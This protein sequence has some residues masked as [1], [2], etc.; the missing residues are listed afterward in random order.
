MSIAPLREPAEHP[1]QHLPGWPQS[2]FKIA[3]AYAVFGL[4]WIWITDTLLFWLR[5]QSVNDY[6]GSTAKGSLFVV[7]SAL[8][9]YLISDR[10]LRNLSRVSALLQ[11]VIDGTT[12]AIFVKDL[13]GRYLLCNDAVAQLAGKSVAEIL[14]KDD[15][16]LFDPESARALHQLDT[17][18]MSD[19][20][21]RTQEEVLTSDGVTRVYSATKAPY[22]DA[23]GKVI[24]LIG[25]S[26]DITEQ[27]SAEADLH[28]R[29]AQITALHRVGVIC[30]NAAA[31]DD[32]YAQ[33]TRLIANELF[34]DNCGFL[35]VDDARKEMVT[36]P[37]YV[38]SPRGEGPAERPLGAGITGQVAQTGIPY[39]TGNVQ[40]E[41]NYIADVPTMNS[42]LCVPIR[43]GAEVL[44]VLNVESR[45][46]DAFT[47]ADESALCAMAELV[48][49]A[50]GRLRNE[51]RLLR[52]KERFLAF[53]RN[54]PGLAWIKNE[55]GQYVFGNQTLFQAI[56]KTEDEI[57]GHTDVEVLPPETAF[58]VQAN[59]REV[60][61]TA[62]SIQKVE[63]LVTSNGQRH[64]YLVNKFP[65]AV[66]GEE[67]RL[68][69][70]IAT[71][72]T[73][74]LA[75]EEALKQSEARLR[76]ALSASELGVWEWNIEADQIYWSPECLKITGA[77]T[78]ASKLE[79][80]SKVIHPDDLAMV[81]QKITQAIDCKTPFVAEFRAIGADGKVRWLY[82]LGR[83]EY[84]E[85]GRP[86]RMI[87]A[88]QDITERKGSQ[89]KLLL[90]K[91]L[92]DQISDSIEVIDP[93]S[94]R[95]LDVNERG[96]AA[97]GYTRNEFLQLTVADVNSNVAARGWDA[98]SKHIRQSKAT[99]YEAMRR[100]KSGS[101]FPVEVN[102][103]LVKLDREYFLAVV[104]DI[105]ERKK[106]E[107]QFQHAQKMEAVG[108]LA[109]GIAHDFN[110]LLTVIS[111]YGSILYEQLSDGAAKSAAGGI[112]D[113]G[114]KATRLTKQL[115]A[116]GRMTMV[117]AKVIDLQSLVA[118]SAE[119]L[120]RLIGE[121]IQFSVILD[122]A[123]P[124]IKADPGQI[125]QVI[126]NLVVNARDAM[127]NGGRLTIECGELVV[128][129][130]EETS[131]FEVKP[132]RYARLSVSDTGLGIAPQV[133][134]QIFEPFFTTKPAG[135]GSGLGLAV[136]HGIV[137]QWNGRIEVH[138]EIGIGTSFTILFP[139]VTHQETKNVGREGDQNV[140]GDENILVVEDEETVRTVARLALEMHGYA[141]VEAASGN[142]AMQ[143]LSVATDGF[144]LIVTDVVMPDMGG[145]R[146][147]ELL[148]KQNPSLRVLFM[149]G[150]TEEEIGGD[151]KNEPHSEFIQKPFTPLELARKVRLMLDKKG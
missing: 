44:A 105:T 5:A 31:E 15:H 129:E 136:V 56:G 78:P 36:H 60:L 109:G 92:L 73:E 42:E 149:S 107:A 45:K 13:R 86:L 74:Q 133:R 43:T 134:S 132:G 150:Y 19:G 10:E 84:S 52:N 40:Q 38:P 141:V 39:R 48:G 1:T 124:H 72:V 18:L 120:R 37:S 6:L 24:G 108:R 59:D 71:D 12:D 116:F 77:S 80:L 22:R 55:H 20:V 17:K 82:D 114:S 67:S 90:L 128:S 70:G 35:L 32:I 64:S 58:E 98:V 140:R 88:V 51:N 106:L 142:E 41:P 8:L 131:R 11:A 118:D 125:E 79:D 76:V 146:L 26:R 75:T 2:P 16:V 83:T 110:N 47:A 62:K 99:I 34:P 137:N 27:K 7:L 130:V 94:G 69:G 111:G 53:M 57:I 147:V 54:L 100:Q 95:F 89:E 61:K 63:T 126:M 3:V 97:H 127:P 81:S 33:V 139:A 91:A 123:A 117:E 21:S 4:S 25:I 28:R 122:P 87:G 144:D 66:I 49:N 104:R 68:V 145:S 65:I 29:L 102:T 85:D 96:C 101:E 46:R 119:L 14:G 115:L 23:K 50:I 30:S 138:S 148:R 112:L 93:D 113:A 143:A 103:V 135:A 151:G 9:I 121:D